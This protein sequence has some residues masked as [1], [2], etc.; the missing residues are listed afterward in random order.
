MIKYLRRS[1]KKAIKRN[2]EDNQIW[3]NYRN[4]QGYF[5]RLPATVGKSLMEVLQSH[6]T[7]LGGSCGGGSIYSLRD[8]PVEPNATEPY[9][10]QCTIEVEDPWYSKMEIHRL[11]KIPLT[12]NKFNQPFDDKKRFSCCVTVEKWMDEMVVSLPYNMRDDS[13]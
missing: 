12:L 1:L 4:P 2:S 13:M 11:E 10:Q 7:E 8:K 6:N 9:C 5:E 3:I